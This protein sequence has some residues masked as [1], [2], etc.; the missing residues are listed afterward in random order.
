ME[1]LAASKRIRM[2]PRK[3]RLVVEAM[4]GLKA[5]EAAEW[6]RN[7]DK[8]AAKPV[9]LTLKQGVANAVNNFGLVK[10][11]LVIRRV[12]VAGGPTLKRWRA[13]ARGQAHVIKK[14]TSHLKL[15]LEGEKD[16]AK[17]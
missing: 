3:L 17:S 16:G 1:V 10:S 7:L 9:L 12:E 11:G 14:R 5:V 8:A 15:V 6:L 13:V 4:K 2:A